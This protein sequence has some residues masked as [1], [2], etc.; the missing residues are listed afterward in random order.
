M[1]A[2][3][4]ADQETAIAERS[5]RRRRVELLREAIGQLNRQ[6]REIVVERCL[7][8]KSTK[9]RE[10]GARYAVSSERVRQIEARAL[11][12]MR[13]AVNMPG[14]AGLR[15]DRAQ[16]CRQRLSRPA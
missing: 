9:L 11:K 5:E 12:K 14:P 16:V 3:D 2:D 4:R 1:L 8:D 13:H 10:L 15:P 6:E 7:K